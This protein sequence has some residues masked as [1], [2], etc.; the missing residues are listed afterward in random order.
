MALCD[1]M[2]ARRVATLATAL[3]LALS[4]AAPIPAAPPRNVILFIGDGMGPQQVRAAVFFTGAPLCFQAFGI[5]TTVTTYSANSAVPDSA[6]TAT[7]I[8][9]A[10]KVN[11]GV[12]SVALPGDGHSLRT[13]LEFFKDKG[14]RTGLVTT[15]HMTDATPAAF[16]AHRATRGDSTGVASDYL[17]L[18]RP[19]VL[20]GGGGYGLSPATATAA[21]YEVV[22]D[23]A[24]LLALDTEAAV[25]VSGQFG[26]G[27]LPYE[28]DGLGNLPHLTDMTDVALRVLDNEPA[29]FFLMVEGGK[30]DHA[31]HMLDL[32]RMLYEMIAFDKAVSVALHWAAGRDDTLIIVT[33]DHETGGLQV[34]ADQGPGNYP[35]VTWISPAHTATPV[36]VY[37]WGANAGLIAGL[38]DDAQF[39]DVVTPGVGIFTTLHTTRGDIRIELDYAS[40]PRTA[41]NFLSLAEGSRAW[42]DFE[43]GQ[44]RTAPFYDGLPFYQA[45]R[46]K[47]IAAGS[48]DGTGADGPGYTFADEFHP[49]LRHDQAGVLCMVAPAANA[50]GSRFCVTLMPAPWLDNVNPIF[51]RVFDGLDVAY[52]IAAEPVDGNQR[53]LQDVTITRISVLRNGLEARAFAPAAVIPPLPDVHKL[54]CG[55]AEQGERY[56]LSWDQKPNSRYWLMTAPALTAPAW[57]SLTEQPISAGSVDID[58]FVRAF[59]QSYFRVIEVTYAPGEAGI[60]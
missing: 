4:I 3:L 47:L 59:T 56:G 5:Q 29:G 22:T 50:N 52:G 27:E 31:C 41:A 11:N 53:P 42:V 36:P 44:A 48:R 60:P 13:M 14:K 23:R 37:A 1:E 45:S 34:V 39:Y 32:P 10:R 15:V 16:G 46:G 30:I 54:A 7:A 2:R 40:A 49:A 6:A 26:Y 12:V 24:G 28:R 33:A 43:S 8:A 25:R 9:T 18:S 55:I 51:G 19:N 57:F 35:A 17:S 21:G 38:T 58:A 20:L